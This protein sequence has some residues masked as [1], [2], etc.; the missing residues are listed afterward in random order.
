MTQQLAMQESDQTEKQPAQS[1]DKANEMIK[2][3]Q[4]YGLIP[5]DS[6]GLSP[7]TLV[8]KQSSQNDSVTHQLTDS[9]KRPFLN[10][11]NTTLDRYNSSAG[12]HN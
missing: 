5:I 4:Q 9:T 12:R 8:G 1:K 10:A 3:H 7:Y 11:E 2:Y 6:S